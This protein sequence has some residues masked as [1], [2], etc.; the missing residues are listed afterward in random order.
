V[1]QGVTVVVVNWNGAS[2]LP[3]CLGSLVA[4]TY[5]PL[6]IVV[7]DNASTDDSRGIGRGFDVDWIQLDT[8]TGLAPAMNVGATHAKQPLLLFLNNDMQFPP[9]FVAE[10]VAC[11]ERHPEAGAID[12]LQ[13]EWSTGEIV[14]AATRLERAPGQHDLPGWRFALTNVADDSPTVY[15]SGANTLVSRDVFDEHG[16]WDDRFFAGWEDVDLGWRLWLSDRGPMLASQAVA[17]HDVSTSSRTPEGLALRSEA[18]MHGRLLFSVKHAP[19]AVIVRG[20]ARFVVAWL[21]AF[22][23]RDR[24]GLRARARVVGRLR[25]EAPDAWRWRRRTY[26]AHGTTPRRHWERMSRV[27]SRGAE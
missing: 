1:A 6:E 10:L 27:P 11:Y 23:R 8:N 25:R 24:P 13:R 14:H 17:D 19:I 20:A 12:A 15:S 26:K 16:G 2:H 3:Q 5:D 18:A 21:V 4:Q 22:A 7:V 9:E